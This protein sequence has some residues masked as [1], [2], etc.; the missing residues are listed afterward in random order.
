L[1]RGEALVH[2]LAKLIDDLVQLGRGYSVAAIAGLLLIPILIAASSRMAGSVLCTTLLSLVSLM[3][4]IA[5]AAA[6]SS[7]AI[8]SALGSFLVAL[9]SIIDRRRATA[10]SRQMT[11]LTERVQQLESAEERRLL[12][13][14]RGRQLESP[15]TPR[16]RTSTLKS[17]YAKD[18]DEHLRVLFKDFEPRLFGAL[19]KRVNLDVLVAE[20]E[21][22]GTSAQACAIHAAAALLDRAVERLGE[23]GRSAVLEAF[24]QK[25]ETNKMYVGLS[26]MLATVD[27]FDVE[28]SVK[29][30]LL[31]G[32]IGR[33]KGV[34]R[35]QIHSWWT[36]SE[37][38]RVADG[39]E[40]DPSALK[41]YLEAFNLTHWIE[42]EPEP[43][44]FPGEKSGNFP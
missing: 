38:D 1:D 15:S 5:P 33:L 8:A 30:M 3:L 36:G 37:V 40:R 14:L 16:S 27:R 20:S 10:L 29:R 23:Q 6:D 19:K 35:E 42:R 32:L 17:Q 18:V 22:T 7:L 31:Y 26:R 9:G 12:L 24:E 21:R 28:A 11:D 25:N 2:G 13:D 41:M 44:S 39:I 43:P 34:S 4:I